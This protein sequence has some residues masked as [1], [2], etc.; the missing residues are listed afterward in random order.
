MG[1]KDPF[2]RKKLLTVFAGRNRRAIKVTVRQAAIISLR[3]EG[4]SCEEI[5]RIYQKYFRTR[6]PPCRERIRSILAAFDELEIREEE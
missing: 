6:R 2:Q 5:G 4:M 3:R 1:K